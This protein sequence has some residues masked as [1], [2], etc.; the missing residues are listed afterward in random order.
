MQRRFGTD[1]T[2]VFDGAEVVG[3]HAGR[4]RTTRVVFS[5]PGVIADDVIR[6][7]IERVPADRQIVVVTNDAEIVRDARAAGCNIVSSNAL[8]ALL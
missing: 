2:I 5:P 4:R 7:E 3:A 1:V 8:L 6:G